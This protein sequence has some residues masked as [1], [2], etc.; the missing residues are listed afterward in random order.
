[1]RHV[2]GCSGELFLAFFDL[3]LHLDLAV[4]KESILRTIDPHLHFVEG[5]FK[6][7]KLLMKQSF[8]FHYL[9]NQGG[10]NHKKRKTTESVN[11]EEKLWMTRTRLVCILT[12]FGVL[13]SPES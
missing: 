5:I 11:R 7:G 2:G 4:K 13:C 6:E 1:M 12:S 8:F 9:A 10:Q 3:E